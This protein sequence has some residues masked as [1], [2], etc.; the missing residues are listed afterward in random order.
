MLN[1]FSINIKGLN[2]SI[3]E[4]KDLV[5]TNTASLTR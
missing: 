4:S 1:I 3:P 2:F 5:K